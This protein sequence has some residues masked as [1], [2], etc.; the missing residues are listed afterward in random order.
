MNSKNLNKEKKEKAIILIAQPSWEHT[1]IKRDD[2]RL[3]QLEFSEEDKKFFDLVLEKANENKVDL[4]VF[5]EFA[6]PQKYHEEIKSWTSTNNVVVV[7]G[8]TYLEREKLFYNT[9]SIFFEGSQYKTEKQKLSPHEISCIKGYGPSPGTD[10][11]YFK[12][13]PIGN[14]GVLICAD[15]FDINTRNELLN[16]DLDI[17]CVIAVQSPGK[18]HHQSIDGIVKDYNEGIYVVYCNALCHPISDGRS[19]FFG[20]DYKESYTELKNLGLS[21]NDGI[22]KRIIEMPNVAGCLIVECNLL[23]KKVTVPNRS[24]T[25]SLINVDLPFVFE[26]KSFRR[27]TDQELHYREESISKKQTEREIP[28]PVLSLRRMLPAKVCMIARV[29]DEAVLHYYRSHA[30]DGGPQPYRYVLRG[31]T[32][33]LPSLTQP[34]WT[35]LAIPVVPRT[36]PIGECTGLTLGFD[37]EQWGLSDDRTS[38]YK[39][40]QSQLAPQLAARGL[41]MDDYAQCRLL[42]V[43]VSEDKTRLDLS[44]GESSYAEWALRGTRLLEEEV[45]QAIQREHVHGE[46]GLSSRVADSLH[47]RDQI[48][49]DFA[50]FFAL[51]QRICLGG[52]QAVVICHQA[53]DHS[54]SCPISKRSVSTGDNAGL[55]QTLPRGF[56]QPLEAVNYSPNWCACTDLFDTITREIFE[57][58]LGGD[59]LVGKH[60]AYVE[61]TEIVLPE[62]RKF[63]ERH[64]RI[65]ITAVSFAL[66]DG[67]YQLSVVI[68]IPQFEE[69]TSAAG[70]LRTSLARA[71]VGTPAD[72]LIQHGRG[73]I[74]NW[75]AERER[76]QTMNFT[77]ETIGH[78]LRS[79]TSSYSNDCWVHGSLLSLAEAVRFLREH[80]GFVDCGELELP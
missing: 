1:Q 67:N 38:A 41:V 19:A 59:R 7:A 79:P 36:A 61:I 68:E 3:F 46:V 12:N 4:I 51:R 9:A 73:W 58:L 34:S 40:A 28:D 72:G 55:I 15:A 70:D 24:S 10:H 33:E 30:R 77:W 63:I 57:E 25:R 54:L 5:P 11:Y 27:L 20:N 43:H 39:A 2:N 74:G 49:P 6:I 42:N 80:R 62:V 45:V 76:I 53:Q 26:N 48:L 8:S 22:D 13:T 35:G 16:V 65:W 37:R 32:I 44:F 31:Q 23:N 64:M 17:L 21:S 52:I 71:L 29:R 47:H 50:S 75:E 18:E 14:I 78:A 56:H 69:F 66:E 60:D